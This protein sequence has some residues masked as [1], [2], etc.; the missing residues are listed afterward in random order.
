L[1]FA[2][3]SKDLLHVFIYCDFVLLAVH[4][5]EIYF[6]LRAVHGTEIYF[7]LHAVHGTEI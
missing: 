7:V 3:I 6:V 5:T 1:N 4:G 2:T